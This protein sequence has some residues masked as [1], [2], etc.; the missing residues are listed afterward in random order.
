MN[1]IQNKAMDYGSKNE[2]NAIATVVSKIAPVYYPVYTFY[3]EGAYMVKNE[4]G[5]EIVVVS[6]D[7]SLRCGSKKP[8]SLEI[9]CP[10][11]QYAG[12]TPVF[13]NVKER[14]IVQS[15]AEAYVLGADEHLYISW[16]KQSSTVF[17]MK[18]NVNLLKKV[19]DEVNRLYYAEIPKRPT[20]IEAETR[21]INDEVKA[22]VF[23]AELLCEIPS[24][25]AS[26]KPAT[27]QNTKSPY[28]QTVKTSSAIDTDLQITDVVQCL[29][30]C[31]KTILEA[32][33]F[34]KPVASEVM[35]YLLSDMD[36]TWKQE[37]GHGLP[38]AFLYKGYSFPM[39][40]ARG[41]SEKVPK[42]CDDK[43]IHVSCVAFDGQFA[44]LK[45]YDSHGNPM[46][47]FAFQR[48]YWTNV[49]KMSKKELIDAIC[50][51][52]S[53]LKILREIDSAQ[54]STTKT[55]HNGK[56]VATNEKISQ[57]PIKSH[58][59]VIFRKVKLS[60][61]DEFAAQ[62]VDNI[63]LDEEVT[64][65]IQSAL[66]NS[67]LAS[68]Y[69]SEI[70]PTDHEPH[71]EPDTHDMVET[72]IPQSS[73]DE[74]S[75]GTDKN[76]RLLLDDHDFENM[77]Q[78]CNSVGSKKLSIKDASDLRDVFTSAERLNKELKGVILHD[79]LNYLNVKLA[80]FSVAI[81][82]SLKKA[83]KINKMCEVLGIS[84]RL[85]G[86][87][88]VRKRKHVKTLK[89]MCISALKKNYIRKMR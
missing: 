77:F 60:N 42:A 88:K 30:K 46:S 7:G 57:Q 58:P 62:S 84:S 27:R 33:S 5:K 17:R 67:N 14:H 85:T 64:E 56:I 76:I 34:Q 83:E 61:D 13:Y 69:E 73:R 28:Y 11:P 20:R 41:I 74:G 25:V 82:L 70:V 21:K 40:T 45:D 6:P 51:L 71:T 2:I 66:Q 49:K 80:K 23:K 48:Q 81:K 53:K 87:N 36:R 86:E 38:V 44:P 54:R 68:N 1:D 65:I 16:S 9:K 47:L 4:N 8:I 26:S 18:C 35:I 10:F 39:T 12:A 75:T 19:F 3:E 50:L 32:Y 59:D 22:E 43:A 89:T 37:I 72:D 52:Y 55:K 29:V 78:L 24:V 31:K 15:L 63:G 79:I